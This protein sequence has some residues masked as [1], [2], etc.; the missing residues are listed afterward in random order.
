[1]PRG[2]DL[3]P[4]QAQCVG[5]W[6]SVPAMWKRLLPTLL[7]L[8]ALLLPAGAHAGPQQ[9]SVMMDDDSLVYRGDA[10]RDRA[11]KLMKALGVDE[12]RVTV[13]WSVVADG[14]GKTRAR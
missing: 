11:L 9:L 8:V 1:M 10:A 3:R 7:V 5:G 14:A 6:R 12:V 13:L 4:Q 2:G